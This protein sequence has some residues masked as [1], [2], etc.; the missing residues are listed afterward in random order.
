MYELRREYFGKGK[1]FR[2]PLFR[3]CVLYID[4]SVSIQRQL[5]RGRSA[6]DYNESLLTGMGRR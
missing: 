6:R 2:R 1:H 3:V 5:G 4:E